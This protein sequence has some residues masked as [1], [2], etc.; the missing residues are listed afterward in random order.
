MKT[1]MQ[2]T[3]RYIHVFC[4]LPALIVMYGCTQNDAIIL[5]E[6]KKE[7]AFL[8]ERY[9]WS[10]SSFEAKMNASHEYGVHYYS[11]FKMHDTLLKTFLVSVDNSKL[12][13]PYRKYLDRSKALIDSAQGIKHTMLFPADL[14]FLKENLKKIGN[15]SLCSQNINLELKK[16]L[17]KQQ[18]LRWAI[19][20]TD[21][22]GCAFGSSHQYFINSE[23]G[24]RLMVHENKD[25]SV[26]IRLKFIEP[27][28]VRFPSSL[29]FISLNYIPEAD[30]SVGYAHPREMVNIKD[31]I[32]AVE[33][34]DDIFI[35]AK[36]LKKGDYIININHKSVS[37]GGYIGDQVT[38]F[39]FKID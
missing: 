10:I 33:D 5:K 35:K 31:Q 24:F 39:K 22:T 13:E 2:K 28:R 19:I 37:S 8:K 29:D 36:F 6:L 17:F 18:A 23:T 38:D 1:E 21:I 25:S 34:Y 32:I 27:E 30:F 7:T 3:K 4:I 9:Q 20:V 14:R 16:E 11:L 15:D 26:F 12:C